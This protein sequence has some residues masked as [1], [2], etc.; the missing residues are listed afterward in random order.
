[1][2]NV[3]LKEFNNFLTKLCKMLSELEALNEI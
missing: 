3:Q 1:M 2:I